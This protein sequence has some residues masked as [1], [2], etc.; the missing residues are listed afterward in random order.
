MKGR[1]GIFKEYKSR[2]SYYKS[3]H[4]NLGYAITCHKSQGSSWEN[5]IVKCRDL[6]NIDDEKLRWLY[7]AITR[8]SRTVYISKFE[9]HK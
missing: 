2:D 7:T 3:L 6:K 8:A 9:E 5:V 1:R 4:V